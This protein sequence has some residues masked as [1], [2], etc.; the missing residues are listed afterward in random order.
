MQGNG[1]FERNHKPQREA[2]GRQVPGQA[3]DWRKLSDREKAQHRE[4]KRG[5]TQ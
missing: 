1:T 4:H 3:H 2:A 5:W